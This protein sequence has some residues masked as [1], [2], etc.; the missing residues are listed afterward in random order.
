MTVRPLDTLLPSPHR[1]GFAP[2]RTPGRPKNPLAV[3]LLTW[4]ARYRM[5]RHISDLPDH[6]LRDIGITRD[7]LDTEAQKPFWRA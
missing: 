5:R 1:S 4:N 6:M 7:M 2:Y 3:L